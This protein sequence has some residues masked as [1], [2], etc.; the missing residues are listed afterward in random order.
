MS[1]VNSIEE[2]LDSI[3]DEKLVA[4]PEKE[5]TMLSDYQLGYHL[6][7]QGVCNLTPRPGTTQV[8]TMDR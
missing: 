8:A 7:F 1:T 3:E 6:D 2:F 4:F 5:G